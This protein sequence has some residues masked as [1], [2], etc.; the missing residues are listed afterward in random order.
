MF[1]IITLINESKTLK[2]H[3]SCECK[4]KV[5]GRK[6]NSN[7]KWN[8]DICWCECKKHN[9]CEKAYIW[10]PPICSCEYGKCLANIIDDSVITCGE[11]IEEETKTVTTNFNEK[12]AVC[13]TKS[14]YILLVFLLV[15]FALLIAASIYC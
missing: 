9:I 7:Q 5:H 13:K 15:T 1:N 11:T 14:F 3:I 10:N 6:C 2:R 4:C 12:H 8:N